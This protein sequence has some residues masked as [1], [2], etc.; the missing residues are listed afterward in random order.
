[1]IQTGTSLTAITKN[2]DGTYTL[3]L[4]RGPSKFTTIADRVILTL[5]FSVLRNLDYH[6][7]GF[8]SVKNNAI[9]QLGYGTNAKLHLQFNDRLWNQA[10]PWGISTGT[11][12]SDTGY[13]NTWD[14]TRAQPGA[15]GILVDY[16][17]GNIGASFTDSPNPSVLNSYAL[18]FLSQIDSQRAPVFPG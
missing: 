4:K 14:V 3:G 7:A 1:S 18:Q 6:S 17:G 10:G 11:S 13:Q 9:Q 15:T 5:P 8:N 2:A 12:Y 16:T